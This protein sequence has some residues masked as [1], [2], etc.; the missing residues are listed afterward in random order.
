MQVKIK[1]HLIKPKEGNLRPFLKQ[2][3]LFLNLG[4]GK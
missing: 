2:P 4:G 3:I 1:N